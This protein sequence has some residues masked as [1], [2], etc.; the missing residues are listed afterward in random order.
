MLLEHLRTLTA[1][2]GRTLLLSDV[3]KYIERLVYKRFD[4]WDNALLLATGKPSTMHKHTRNELRAMLRAIYDDKN[5]F[6]EIHDLHTGIFQRIKEAFGTFYDAVESAVGSSQ[7]VVILNALLE[8]TPNQCPTAS[9][10]EITH[11][12]KASGF[13]YSNLNI[14]SRLKDLRNTGFVEGGKI[15][16]TALWKLTA[17]GKEFLKQRNTSAPKAHPPL[18]ETS[19][20]MTKKNGLQEK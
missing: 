17:K 3:S 4:S 9:T 1:Q 7:R 13:P 10:A 20:S 14:S 6:P 15:N 12:L 18:A 5:R 16:R 11:A 19:L 2:K 8:L